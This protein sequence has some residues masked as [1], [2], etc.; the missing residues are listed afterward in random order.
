M[1]KFRPFSSSRANCRLFA[2]PSAARCNLSSFRKC[3]RSSGRYGLSKS[4]ATSMVTASLAGSGRKASSQST[5]TLSLQ[6]EAIVLWISGEKMFAQMFGKH[7]SPSSG[8]TDEGASTRRPASEGPIYAPSTITAFIEKSGSLV[9]GDG[10]FTYQMKL[11]GAEA[12]V[13][14]SGES[15]PIEGMRRKLIDNYFNHPASRAGLD[16]QA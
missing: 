7:L 9:V 6:H 14:Y 2:C 4:Q 13:T 8:Q 12:Y 15:R 1:P 16:V 11:I 3:T 10:D 5:T